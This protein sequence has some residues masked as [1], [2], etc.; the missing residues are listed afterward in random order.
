MPLN[1][2][3]Q[4]VPTSAAA[5]VRNSPGGAYVVVRRELGLK[6]RAILPQAVHTVSVTEQ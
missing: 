2:P 5:Y 4:Y 6:K 1:G 3:W